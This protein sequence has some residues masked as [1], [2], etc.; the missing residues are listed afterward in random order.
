MT[1]TAHPDSFTTL[2]RAFYLA[3]PL[4][5]AELRRIWYR[6]WLYLGHESEIPEPGDFVTRP[7]L[8]ENV[9]LTRDADGA[10][11]ALL[12]VC[13]H[14]GARMV[15]A[16]CG[17]LKRVVCP[18]HQWTYGLD[19]RLVGAPSMP[20]GDAIDYSALGLYRVEV[21]TWGGF[22]FGCLGETPPA[23]SLVAE[24]QDLAPSLDRYEPERLRVAATRIYR[25][26]AN[27]KV[28]LENYLECYHCSASH[29]EFCRTA[30]LRA[31][32]TSEYA[33]Q[34][35]DPRPYWAT[36]VPLRDGMSTVSLTGEYVS[37]VALGGG[38]TFTRG[39]SRS[40]GDWAGAAVLYFY[41]DYAMV[42][43][44]RPLSALET[45]FVL[46]WL[47]NADAADVDVDLD[48]LTHVWDMTTRQDV[49]LIE[50]TQDGLRS[51]RYTPGPLSAKHEPYI[52]SSLELYLAAMEGDETVA[53]LMGASG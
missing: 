51:R 34:A 48:A 28:M 19:G 45:E 47:V 35:W 1:A 53:K 36:D 27:W 6:R 13:R 17:R 44:I 7:M 12:N 30:D 33:A 42:H 25:C 11:T 46:T 21:E 49:E 22:V 9:L 8:D 26:R 31:R 39:Q 43:A 2:P 10:V 16:P 3:G 50:R 41:A 38:E 40:F 37:R 20:D 24:L 5:E 23:V 18:Y 32:S 4:L 15:D 52:R 29:P 14:R